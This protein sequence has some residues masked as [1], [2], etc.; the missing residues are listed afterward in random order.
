MQTVYYKSP[1]SYA[2]G[3]RPHAQ[4]SPAIMSAYKDKRMRKL[5]DICAVKGNARAYYGCGMA[6]AV[7]SLCTAGG[8]SVR[9]GG[10]ASGPR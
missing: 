4:N 6:V 3:T 2:R 1:Y 7:S 10:R 5:R 9:D 8:K